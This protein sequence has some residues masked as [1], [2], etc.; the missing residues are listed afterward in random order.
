MRDND[1][2]VRFFEANRAAGS[3]DIGPTQEKEMN[4]I[5][6]GDI[7]HEIQRDVIGTATQ[8]AANAL[9]DS[10]ETDAMVAARRVAEAAVLAW[11][12]VNGREA[13]PTTLALTLDA[14]ELHCVIAQ[15]IAKNGPISRAIRA[16]QGGCGRP[17]RSEQG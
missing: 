5:K 9:R 1:V 16:V 4:D 6:A 3:A 10:G 7:P 15:D 11:Q 8:S 2:A 17:A 13:Q 12:I 14:K